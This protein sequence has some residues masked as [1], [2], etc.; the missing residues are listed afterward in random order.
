MENKNVDV[1]EN[2]GGTDV[3]EATEK[4]GLFKKGLNFVGNHKVGVAIVAG[5][6]ALAGIGVA[7]FKV[8]SNKNIEDVDYVELEEA[9]LDD[10]EN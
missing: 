10:L 6:T 9:D 7:A 5:L 4:V 2:V 3:V 8:I 1:V